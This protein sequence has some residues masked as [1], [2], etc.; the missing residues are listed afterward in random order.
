MASTSNLSNRSINSSND[1]M[2]RNKKLGDDL[3]DLSNGIE[4]K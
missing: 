3:I 2:R 1:V 4:D